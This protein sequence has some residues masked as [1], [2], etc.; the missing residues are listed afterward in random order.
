MRAYAEINDF[1]Q[2]LV[3]Q[4]VGLFPWE[5]VVRDG[6]GSDHQG[7]GRIIN[8]SL[9]G[10]C[11]LPRRLFALGGLDYGEAE[12]GRSPRFQ[13]LPGS[14][15]E[16]R[17]LRGLG[18]ALDLDE[19]RQVYLPLSR[20]LSMYVE[21]ARAF[22]ERIVLP[23]RPKVIVLYVEPGF[24]S[25]GG[26]IDLWFEADGG[27]IDLLHVIRMV[28]VHDLVEIDAGDTYC[29]DEAGYADK[30]QRET[31]AAER[32]FNLLPA[33]QAG[34]IRALWD[35]FEAAA[36]PEARFANALDRLQP[37]IDLLERLI[38]QFCVTKQT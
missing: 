22:A 1:E 6:R 28:L 34:E 27:A 11:P 17:S 2:Q 5:L 37:T 7:R 26:F 18:D 23:Y 20:M 16:I 24:G 3:E 31:M 32:I 8:S 19:V 10:G 35:E 15:E 21:A 30:T 14:A 9:S 29:Y 13:P 12:D 25:D 33:D 4:I 38:R 36:T